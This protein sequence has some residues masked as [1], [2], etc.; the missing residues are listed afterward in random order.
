LI[1]AAASTQ[2]FDGIASENMKAV[3]LAVVSILFSGG[4][5]NAQQPPLL[6]PVNLA[7]FINREPEHCESRTAA[8]DGI[9][10]KTPLNEAI[11]VIARLGVTETKPNLNWRRL[12][13]VRAYWTQGVAPPAR[14]NP[15]TIILAQGERV[16][17]YGRLEFYV[18]GK[19]VWVLNIP[20]N[21]DIDFGDCVAPDDSY[22]RHRVYDPCWVKAHRI[23]YPCRDRYLRRNR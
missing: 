18:G 1:R 6:T 16:D 10:Q 9:T 23:F 7:D 19:L 17:G 21:A 4:L 11:I 5:A 20:R 8:V 12:Q 22:V 3:I 14:R 13:N 15:E 2:T